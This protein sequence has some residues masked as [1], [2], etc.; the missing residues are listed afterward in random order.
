M[1][2]PPLAPERSTAVS[3]IKLVIYLVSVLNLFKFLKEKHLVALQTYTRLHGLRVLY[4][5]F[6]CWNQLLKMK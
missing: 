5:E 1:T 6:W 4:L 3:K 2:L